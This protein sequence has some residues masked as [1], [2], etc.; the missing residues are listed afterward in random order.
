MRKGQQHVLCI[1][2]DPNDATSF[3]R[4]AGVIGEMR[5]QT[6]EFDFTP[7]PKGMTVTWSVLQQADWMF[8]QRPFTSGHLQMA[9]MAKSNGMKVWAD[10]DDDILNIPKSNYT[11]RIYAAKKARE[12]VTQLMEYLDFITVSTDHLAT[13]FGAPERKNIHVVPNA[14]NTTLFPLETRKDWLKKQ[15]GPLKRKRVFWR[16]GRTHVQDL[17]TFEKPIVELINEHQDWEFGF[18][19]DTDWPLL[20]ALEGCPNARIYE[21]QDVVEYHRTYKCY[22]AQIAWV[23]LMHNLFNESKSMCAWL[24]ATFAGAACLG[25]NFD[26]WKRPGINNYVD[27]QEFYDQMKSMLESPDMCLDLQEQSVKTI[28]DQNLE[29]KDTAKTR[30]NL[31]KKYS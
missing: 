29:L 22:G 31:L 24:E 5:K 15:S 26:E 20:V 9:K 3:Y 12:N 21:A 18:C 16:G 28:R 2:P 17:L 27:E 7:C 11:H 25:P 14:L 13:I 6:D 23:P 4:G 10:W 1:S 8:L 30:I 19:G